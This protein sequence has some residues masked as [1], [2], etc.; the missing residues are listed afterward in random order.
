[1]PTELTVV[2]RRDAAARQRAQASRDELIA[3]I[4]AAYVE[5][6]TVREIAQETGLSF[7]R[8]YQLVTRPGG[9]GP[10]KLRMAGGEAA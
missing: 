9:P 5:G 7:Q 3:A 2:A 6:R 4:D 10:R 8:I 1:M